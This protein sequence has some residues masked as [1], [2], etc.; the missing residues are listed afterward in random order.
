MA[1]PAYIPDTSAYYARLLEESIHQ[2]HTLQERRQEQF[3]VYLPFT[4]TSSEKSTRTFF[5]QCTLCGPT[6]DNLHNASVRVSEGRT[7]HLQLCDY[8]HDL[9]SVSWTRTLE[10][11]AKYKVERYNDCF[12]Q[13]T[14]V[15]IFCRGQIEDAFDGWNEVNISCR[16]CISRIATYQR[17]YIKATTGCFGPY[18]LWNYLSL[19]PRPVPI[20]RVRM[21]VLS[22]LLKDH[23]GEDVY[24]RRVRYIE[25]YYD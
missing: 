17:A 25:S 18:A 21:I 8:C 15:C 14:P 3:P 5:S 11:R 20:V 9:G 10:R 6:T 7:V 16:S 19:P 23:L 13:S 1:H 2:A 24:K 12:P 4:D 22:S